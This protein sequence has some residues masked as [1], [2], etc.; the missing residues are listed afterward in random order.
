MPTDKISSVLTEVRRQ[1]LTLMHTIGR[2]MLEAY[3]CYEE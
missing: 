1:T 3:D 2:L